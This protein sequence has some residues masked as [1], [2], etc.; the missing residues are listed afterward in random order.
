M[1]VEHRGIAKMKLS[2]LYG[3]RR[4]WGT[5]TSSVIARANELFVVMSTCLFAS[6]KPCSRFDHN[7]YWKEQLKNVERLARMQL[8]QDVR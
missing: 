7:P 6:P 8:A 4:S 3:V 5:R 2:S 1:D